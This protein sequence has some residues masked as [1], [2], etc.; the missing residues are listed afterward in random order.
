[1]AARNAKKIQNQTNGKGKELR[2]GRRRNMNGGEGQPLAVHFVFPWC[3][4]W[5]WR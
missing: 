1:M 2:N 3:S 5:P 4:W